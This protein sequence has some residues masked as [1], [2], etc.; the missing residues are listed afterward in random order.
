[1]K[2]ITLTQE[3][4]ALVDDEDFEFLNKWKWHAQKIGNTFYAARGQR[5]KGSKKQITFYLHRVIMNVTNKNTLIDHKDRNGLN[6]QKINLR[7][8]NRSENGK[9]RQSRKSSTSKYLG[10]Y[11][12][13]TYNRYTAEIVVMGK[14]KFLGRY[15]NETDAAK[16]YDEAAKKIHGKFANLNL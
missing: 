3:K 13:N 1:M 6:C 7:Q 8:C 16:A 10:V 2:T 11:Y 5:I 15:V 9:N 4:V 12:C 14:K